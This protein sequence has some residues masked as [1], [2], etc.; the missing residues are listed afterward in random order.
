MG[1]GGHRAVHR[2][3]CGAVLAGYRAVCGAV[4]AGYVSLASS[5]PAIAAPAGRP[6]VPAAAP[7]PAYPA[8]LDYAAGWLTASGTGVADRHAPSPAVALGTSRRGAEQSARHKLAAML[9]KLPL[10]SGGTVGD[11]LAAGGAG[12]PLRARLDA[13]VDAAIAIAAEPETDGSWRVTLAVPLEAIRLA[14]AEPRALP[15]AGDRDPPVIIVDGV[16]G[17]PAIGWT[18][19]AVPAATL[20]LEAPPAWAKDAPHATATAVDHGAI[21]VSSP[22]GPATLYLLISRK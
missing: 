9:A 5:S 10:A 6:P 11:Q 2:A 7:A 21:T 15:A 17:T 16:T 3:V 19:N 14:L 18:I 20:W 4:L 1:V 22:G 12:G 13:A 8:H